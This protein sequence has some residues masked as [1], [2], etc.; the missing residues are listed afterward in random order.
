MIFIAEAVAMYSKWRKW[1]VLL[2]GVIIMLSACNNNQDV[3]INEPK[4][5]DEIKE[6]F[7]RSFSEQELKKALNR[8]VEDG[9]WECE[10]K[11]GFIRKNQGTMYSSGDT[12]KIKKAEKL[13]NGYPPAVCVIMICT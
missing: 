13:S 7:G 9:F 4:A 6:Y 10:Y 5:I 3:V 8:A 1:M 12:F 11:D 2:T